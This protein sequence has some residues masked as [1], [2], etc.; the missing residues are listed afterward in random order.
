MWERAFILMTLVWIFMCSPSSNSALHRWYHERF[1]QYLLLASVLLIFAL[2]I[3]IKLDCGSGGLDWNYWSKLSR[4]EKKGGYIKDSIWVQKVCTNR[5]DLLCAYHIQL[6][7]LFKKKYLGMVLKNWVM[8]S[9]KRWH[10]FVGSEKK[11][12]LSSL[13]WT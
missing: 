3:K 8:T 9:L 1:L 13:S 10:F 4:W 2:W 6:R 11:L 12:G 7:P 5:D